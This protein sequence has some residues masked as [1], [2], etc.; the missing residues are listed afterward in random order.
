MAEKEYINREVLLRDLSESV[1]FSCRTEDVSQL[2][3]SLEK[4]VT[5]IKSQ[6]TAD[7]AEVKHGEW[8]RHEDFEH[9]WYECSNC[10]GEPLR[11]IWGVTCFTEYC[12][13][14]GAKMDGGKN[15]K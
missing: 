1:I 12:P 5:C 10:G 6:P 13:Y 2:K 4:L 9:C 15:G 7:V 3:K 14:C 11:S 8:N